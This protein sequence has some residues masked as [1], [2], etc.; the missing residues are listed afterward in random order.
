MTR[1]SASPAAIL[2]FACVYFFDGFEGLASVIIAA[3]VHEAGHFVAIRAF[4]GRA[5]EMWLDASGA[6]I[7][8]AGELGVTGSIIA[9]LSGPA[10]GI[11]LALICAKMPQSNLMLRV[12]G[13][14]LA[15]SAYNLLPALP[16]DGGR[17]LIIIL[18]HFLS[19]CAADNFMFAL[20]LIIGT[21][22]CVAG[23]TFLSG[24]IG[25]TLVAAGLW[26]LA[27][28]SGLVKTL[29]LV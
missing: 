13:V 23:L 21:A 20:G 17:A 16:L 14:S 19:P 9:L 6:C 12:C 1:F 10:A 29:R 11:A 5:A 18:K 22:L 8:T 3:A 4:G 24:S 26:I 28:Q 2:I 15:L 25:L 7:V 27:A